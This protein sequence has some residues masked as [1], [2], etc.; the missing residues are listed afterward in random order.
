[1]ATN[2]G[3]EEPLIANTFKPNLE[4]LSRALI[5]F[6]AES[7]RFCGATLCLPIDNQAKGIRLNKMYQGGLG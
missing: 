2:C 6:H 1:M 5:Y 4:D 3:T 7:G